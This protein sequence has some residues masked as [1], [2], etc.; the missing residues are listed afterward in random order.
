MVDAVTPIPALTTEVATGD[1]PVTVFPGGIDGGFLQNPMQAADQNIGAAE[2][3]VVNPVG[4]AVAPGVAGGV[5][6]TNFRI[7]PGG[8][9]SAI[10]GQTTPTS[11]NAATSGH[12]FSGV[13][14]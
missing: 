1:T 4:N 7:G 13:Q 11:V 2:D 14:W 3:I 8:S 10:P 6:G 5:N 12:K 9:W